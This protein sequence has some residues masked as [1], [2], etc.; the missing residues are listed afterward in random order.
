MLILIACEESGVVRRALRARGHNAYSCDLHPAADDSPWHLQGNVLDLLH[1]GWDMMIAHPPCTHLAT[2]GARWFAQKQADGRQQEAIKF[3][4]T[5]WNSPIPLIA[6]ENPVS[7]LST[8]LRKPDQII[9]PYEYGHEATKTTCLWL[10][11]LP[12]LRP[13]HIV[14]RGTRTVFASGKSLPAW[15]NISP[16]PDRAKLRSRTF[17]GIADAMA[18]QWAGV[19][20]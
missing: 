19:A 17:P 8:E 16:S 2:S 7:I 5:L 11:G 20:A 6:L 13:T 10:K 18:E 1:V 14:G 3:A 12:K 9:Q 15:Y 4:L